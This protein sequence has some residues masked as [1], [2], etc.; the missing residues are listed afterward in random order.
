M[1]FGVVA[2]LGLGAAPGDWYRQIRKPSFTPPGWVF[3]PV[4]TLLYLSMAVAVWL[5]W[6]KAGFAAAPLAMAVFGAQLF[7]NGL[8]SKLFF[9][10]HNPGLALV[11]IVLLWVAIAGTIVSFW[12]VSPVAG[13]ALLPYL[14]WVSFASVL[15]YSVWALNR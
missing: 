7:L 9:G 10:M 3:G 6:L 8:W 4:W 12:R 13:A 1:V 5:V 15:N 11:D 2:A 14:T